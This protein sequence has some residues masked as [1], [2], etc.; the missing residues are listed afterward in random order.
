MGT[1]AAPPDHSHG[2]GFDPEF[3]SYPLDSVAYG[4]PDFDFAGGFF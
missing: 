4:D 1:A 3:D 2:S